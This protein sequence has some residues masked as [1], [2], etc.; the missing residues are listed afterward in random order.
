VFAFGI[1]NKKALVK[2]PEL[3]Y[4]DL[5]QGSI[6]AYSHLTQSVSYGLLHDG[7]PTPCGHWLFAYADGNRE[8]FYD[9]DDEVGMYVSCLISFF[10]VYPPKL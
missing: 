2:I 8:R 6:L 5:L 4:I 3:N 10:T 1:P 7:W 9:D